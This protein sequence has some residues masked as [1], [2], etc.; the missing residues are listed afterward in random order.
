MDGWLVCETNTH[1]QQSTSDCHRTALTTA[2]HFDNA[3]E[4]CVE[5]WR[6]QCIWHLQTHIQTGT[7]IVQQGVHN[8]VHTDTEAHTHNTTDQLWMYTAQHSVI[9]V[10]YRNLLTYLIQSKAVLLKRLARVLWHPPPTMATI[11]I[12]RL[13]RRDTWRQE[14]DW[15]WSI[16]L[17]SDPATRQ[18]GFN[19]PRR[20]SSADSWEAKVSVK[21]TCV[22]GALSHQ[23]SVDVVNGR[24]WST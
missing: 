6:Q 24:W 11:L 20:S 22:P 16:V 18:Q 15:L 2:T 13:L 10:C 12:Y 4:V 21:S 3:N 17:V 8:L 7:N 1:N 19:L 9:S 14:K 5:A 23:S